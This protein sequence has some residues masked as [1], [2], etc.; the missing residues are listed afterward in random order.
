MHDMQ[1]LSSRGIQKNEFQDFH[2]K[3]PKK[4]EYESVVK[5]INQPVGMLTSLVK[6][7]RMDQVIL[8]MQEYK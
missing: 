6:I 1:V 8:S 7:D 4:L 2:L 3:I 5:S